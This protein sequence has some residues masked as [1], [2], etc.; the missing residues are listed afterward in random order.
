MSNRAIRIVLGFCALCLTCVAITAF[1]TARV[2]LP[3]EEPV[4]AGYRRNE[5][6]YVEMRDGVQI[7]V[8]IWLPPDLRAGVRVP[9]LM[10]TT[11]YWRAA[12]PGWL[13]RVLVA[14]HLKR[15]DGLLD[16]QVLF[17]SRQGFAVIIADAR[18]SGA[19]SGTRI[20]ELSPDEITDLGEL[21]G[22]AARQRWSN[23]R[24]ATFGVSYVGNTAELAAVS[25]NPALRAVG[26]FYNDF[27]MMLGFV[28]P[29]GVYNIGAVQPWSDWVG[30]Q[31]RND[32]CGSFTG[33]RCW[34]HRQL[35]PGVKP[36]DADTNGEHL[37]TI[38]S[39][40]HNPP[41]TQS[42]GKPEF[43][44][45]R[46][47][48][49]N[50]P[51]SLD[52]IT[53]YGLRARIEASRVPMMVW[54]SWLDAGTCDGSLSRYRNFKN[55]QQLVIGAFSH[56]GAY[57]IDPFLPLSRHTP[58]DPPIEERNRMEAE[59]FNHFL[60][61]DHPEPLASSVRYYT[62]GEGKWHT[63]AVWPPAGLT[64]KRYYL[65]GAAGAGSTGGSDESSAKVERSLSLEPPTAIS[66]SDSYTVDFSTTTGMNSR[67]QLGN[68]I[69]PDRAAE[70]RKLLTYTGAPLPTDVEI[71]GTPVLTL[72]MAS[73]RSDGALFAYLEDVSPQGRVTYITEGII[74]VINRRIAK[75]ALPYTP[76]GP[77]HSF[78]R[79]DAEPLIPGQAVEISFSLLP[80]SVVLRRGHRIR[81]AVAGADSPMFER[82]PAEGTPRLE[83]YREKDKPSYLE[84][85]I[86]NH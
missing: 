64:M 9:V 70:D 44:D 72:H 58:P 60:R 54:C 80:T 78:L 21:I 71:T 63:S 16:P 55:P 82:Y 62:I 37:A 5:A 3:G 45:D 28:R 12:R 13:F 39:H 50:G 14:I 46:I 75:N 41:L 20:T 2:R 49:G 79:A 24:V 51:I 7:A 1:L 31:D 67:W 74:R 76:L 42:F 81:L 32:V 48:T 15:A 18:G 19:S 38:L 59:F 29:G 65:V 84:L 10:Q 53:P 73:S 40:R 30:A 6:I 52:Q 83:V 85:P 27:D 23:G 33:L 8:D 77:P 22:W 61:E 25:E 35:T 68:V 17:F 36:V 57:N 34:Y 86:K 69:Y 66:A 11:R 4:P 47:Q 43:R 26:A 56:G